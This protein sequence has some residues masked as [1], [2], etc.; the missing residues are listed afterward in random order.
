MQDNQLNSLKAWLVATSDEFMQSMSQH[1]VALNALLTETDDVRIRQEA[2]R[3]MESVLSRL[4]LELSTQPS[5]TLSRKSLAIVFGMLMTLLAESGPY[6]YE[7]N[8][9]RMEELEREALGP[10]RELRRHTVAVSKRFFSREDFYL[11]E[12]AIHE[13]IFPLLDSMLDSGRYMPFRVIQTTR[14]ADRLFQFKERVNQSLGSNLLHLLDELCTLKY[15]RF[16]TSGIRGRWGID[17]TYTKVNHVTQ[18]ICDYLRARDVPPYV[19]PAAEDLRGRWIVVG[20]DGRKHS[21]EVAEWV[22]QVCLNNGFKVWFLRPATPTPAIIY[23]AVE[24]LGVDQIAGILNCTA[25]HNPPEWQGIKFNPRMGYPA[26]TH[27]TDFIAARANQKQLLQTPEQSYDLERAMA[28]GQLKKADPLTRY[29]QWILAS[30]QTD[31]R[32]RINENDRIRQFFSDK[33]VVID[34]MYGAGHRY[35]SRILG[36]LGVRHKVIHGEVNEEGQEALG[37]MN[38]EPPFIFDLR[39]EVKKENAALGIATDT[40]ADRF[41]IIDQGGVYFRPNQIL[42]MLTKYLLVDR[43]LRGRV[44]I[45]Q[46]GLPMI[47][48][49]AG[50]TEEN[51]EFKPKKGV[52]PAYVDH[53]FY[54]HR[55][56]HR[57]DAVYDNVFIVP[58]GIKYIIEIATMDQAYVPLPELPL[59]W[60]NNLLIGGE[61]SSG[62]TTKG[63]VP[64]KD[65][66]WANLLVMDMMAYY[67]KS[68]EEIW[69]TEIVHNPQLGDCWETFGGRVD[70]DAS[71]EAKEALLNYYLDVFKDPSAAEK[72]IAGMK[73]LYLGGVRYDLV[74]IR[75]VDDQGNANHW[76]R[77]RASGTEPLNRIYTESGNR[78]A[79]VRIEREVLERLNE[80]SAQVIRSA[81]SLWRLVDIL[82]FT[83]R[84]ILFEVQGIR[85]R[86]LEQAVLEVLHTK[87]WY[88]EDLVAR[89]RQ[90][91][92]CVEKRNQK[93]VADWIAWL[94]KVVEA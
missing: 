30:G 25:S 59:T 93:V 91:M 73:V 20:F 79:R 9:A 61:E 4:E 3:L 21:E 22:A 58:V 26:P 6:R 33:K 45:T 51:T 12:D 52:I 78:E 29:C 90:K 8:R 1:F 18:A 15:P 81:Y 23:E 5:Q 36:E 34:E 48:K 89:L 71:D 84:D 13:E 42:A 35:L 10:M 53:A 68:L 94:E 86:R 11:L 31:Q 28:E 44:V 72:T 55:I 37:Y 60:R 87:N 65:G 74:E 24:Y 47:D 76:L 82:S 7:T 67:R 50:Y 75:L 57:E 41:G 49:I 2:L 46:T 43:K 40:D 64:D 66:I 27:L 62:L 32:I 19:K 14:I 85:D 63:H 38:P 70:V 77:M 39:D 54:I 80:F 92:P 56:G 88:K 16:G 83:A 17:F 69:E